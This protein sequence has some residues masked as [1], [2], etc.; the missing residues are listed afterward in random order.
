MQDAT[1]QE[2]NHRTASLLT[3]RHQRARLFT[4]PYTPGH[5]ATIAYCCAID[6]APADL[7]LGAASTRLLPILIIQYRPPPL[8]CVPRTVHDVR[9]TALYDLG[10]GAHLTWTKTGSI[11]DKAEGQPRRH[12]HHARSPHSSPPRTSTL[13]PP[14]SLRSVFETNS[15]VIVTG[16]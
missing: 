5:A 2:N 8:S 12:T 13:T 3:R 10:G 15:T 9:R 11:V 14:R 7:P 1:R 4:S 6:L 16:S